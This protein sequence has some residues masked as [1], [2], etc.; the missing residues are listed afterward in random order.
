MRIW[1]G[2]AKQDKNC[3][4]EM[5]WGNEEKEVERFKVPFQ[6]AF[7]VFVRDKDYYF[8]TE[9]GNVYLARSP[10]KMEDERKIEKVWDGKRNPVHVLITDAS[11]DKV[12]CFVEPSEK[13]KQDE[14]R[15]YF[16]LSA[17][18]ET[19][20]YKLIKIRRRQD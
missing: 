7:T 14:D 17:K 19:M 16:E 9:S 18:P 20:K 15:V 10:A 4:W 5:E 6:E 3:H 13:D 12:Y 8:V 2:T 1:N 11:N